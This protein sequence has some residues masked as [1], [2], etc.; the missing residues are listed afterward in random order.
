MYML[1]V[2]NREEQVTKANWV[3]WCVHVFREGHVLGRVLGFEVECERTKG[4]K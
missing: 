1:D 2:I 4:L 3:H